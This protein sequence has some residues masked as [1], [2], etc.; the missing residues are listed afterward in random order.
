MAAENDLDTEARGDGDYGLDAELIS[1]IRLAIA[2]GDVQR[3]EELFEPL[4]PADIADLLEQLESGQRR[5]LLLIAGRLIGGETLSEL[6]EGVREEVI[7]FLPREVLA[8]AVRDLESDDVVDLLEDLDTPQQEAILGAL[9]LADRVAVEAS[10]SFP[11][12]SAGRLPCR[13]PGGGPRPPGTWNVGGTGGS[14][15]PGRGAAGTDL[16]EQFY[17]VPFSFP[18]PPVH[19]RPR[20]YVHARARS[21]AGVAPRAAGEP[22]R[23]SP[24][25]V[26]RSA[27][28]PATPGKRGEVGPMH[29]TSIT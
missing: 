27:R 17:H 24:E 12:Y 8:E 19:P 18:A 15:F 14:I 26:P 9:E 20:G 29:S 6:E 16:P 7:A 4:H 28:S 2:S 13:G 21:W 25:P 23:I 3:I 10:L 5:E 22:R 11:E 1:S